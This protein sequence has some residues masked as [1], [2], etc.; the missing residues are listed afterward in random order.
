MASINQK[1]NGRWLLQW[2]KAP[3]IVGTKTVDSKA[4]ANEFERVVEGEAF[5]R[6][7]HIIDAD[8]AAL[9][10]AERVPLSQNVSE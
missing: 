1:P 8:A 2:M 3:G 10:A 4:Q 9:S 6:N 7:N 5:R